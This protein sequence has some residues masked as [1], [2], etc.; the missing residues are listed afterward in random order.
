MNKKIAIPLVAVVLVVAGGAA[1]FWAL[2]KPTVLRLPGIVEIQEVRLGSKVGGRVEKL[3]VQ[4]GDIV[5]ANQ[6]LVVFEAPE[7]KNQK[8]Q[9]LAKLASAEADLARAETGPRYEEIDAAKA[10]ADFR[11]GPL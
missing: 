8:L 1:A 3:L 4:E 6:P 11:Q 5:H 7:L 10:T 9:M 2:R